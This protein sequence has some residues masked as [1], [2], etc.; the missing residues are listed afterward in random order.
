MSRR[1]TYSRA[2]YRTVHLVAG[3]ILGAYVYSPLGDVGWFKFTTRDIV[4]PLIMVTGVWLWKGHDIKGWLK[5][6]SRKW[7]AGAGRPITGP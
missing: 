7:N 3:A 5:T 1:A 4:V 2:L 6:A